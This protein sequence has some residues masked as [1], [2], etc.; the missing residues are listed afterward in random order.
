MP[1]IALPTPLPVAIPL[2]KLS[3]PKS[4]RPSVTVVDVAKLAGVSPMTVSR[5]L[6]ARDSVSDEAARRVLEAASRLGYVRNRI[7]GGLR[8]NRSHLVAALVP[9]LSGPVF[10][11]SIEALN[12]ELAVRGY[13]LIVG[14][15]G[16]TDPREDELVSDIISRRPDAIV[17]T[18]T[19]HTP[20][21][22]RRLLGAGVPVV[23]IWDLSYDPID[24]LIGFSHEAVG[25]TVCQYL[26]SRGRR[27]LAL[28]GAD[29]QRSRR[30][31]TAFSHAAI[32]SGLTPPVSHFV[33]APAKLGDGRRA[34]RALLA[35]SDRIDAIFCSSDML[36][37][38]VLIEASTMGLAV[39]ER[40]AVVGFGDLNFAADLEPALTSVR[41]DGQR[42][43]ALA[44]DA[45]VKRLQGEEIPNRIIDVGFT[46]VQRR[47]A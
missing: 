5:A 42:I 8:S 29:D 34:L 21:G 44:A 43:G 13:R 3:V 2:P 30:R 36:A 28:I 1:Y 6:N 37:N 19:I 27:R 9:T 10:L 16:Y 24:M 40:I 11:E 26:H 45:I 17:L 23:E 25:A 18:G 12:R 31:W 22:K 41:V 20:E 39:P 4:A 38:G 15:T 35:E 32:E 47:S 33:S 7:A 46:I 14:Q